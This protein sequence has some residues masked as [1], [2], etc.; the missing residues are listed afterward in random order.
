MASLLLANLR[1]LPL[2]F[3]ALTALGGC[4][5]AGKARVQE[6]ELADLRAELR[7][8]RSE[9]QRL[10]Q[11]VM[12]LEGEA[13]VMRAARAPAHPPV[14][15]PDP[16]PAEEENLISRLE[17]TKLQP[18]SEPRAERPPPPAVPIRAAVREPT[19]DEVLEAL[20]VGGESPGESPGASP[21]EA[22]GLYERG[23]QALRTGDPLGAARA[24]K[25]FAAR[26]P[27]HPQ[28]DN[29]LHFA[30]VGLAAVGDLEGASLLFERV[31]ADHPAGDARMDAMLE[32]AQCRAK[33][34]RRDEARALYLELI[35]TWPGTPAASHAQARLAGLG[36]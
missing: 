27:R 31:L 1:H 20:G 26:H 4:A 9:H 22:E 13:V 2:A 34:D 11:R 6:K 18:R 16:A 8:V 19:D 25:D 35:Q 5:G 3:A 33:L 24:L 14:T 15:A 21:G 23:M 29:A 10:E 17:V 32:L 12:R 36:P 7:A 28:A 30:G